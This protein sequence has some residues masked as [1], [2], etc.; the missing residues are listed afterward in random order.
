MRKGIDFRS[1]FAILCVLILF[2]LI[3]F[4]VQVRSE[5]KELL[6]DQAVQEI[7]ENLQAEYGAPGF[8]VTISDRKGVIGSAS[9]GVKRIGGS[10]PLRPDSRFHIG[11][12]SKPI[13]SSAIGSLV[14]EGVLGWDSRV[15]DLF[16]EF[17]KT[18]KP[19]YG[20][21]T[22]LQLLSHTSGIQ[23]FEEDEEFER[24]PEWNG[25]ARERRKRFAKW[26]FTLKPVAAPGSESVYSNAG[27][28]VAAAMAE[29]A[30]D[31]S[32]EHIVQ[33]TVFDPLGMKSAGVG[34]PAAK[35]ADAP[36]GHS[37]VNGQW[38]AHDP[39]QKVPFSDLIRPAGDFHMT[40]FDLAAFGRA[41]MLGLEGID[42]FLHSSTIR[43]I[44]KEVL[45]GYA[46]GWNVR[47]KYDSHLGGLE[48]LHTALLMIMKEDGRVY[49]LA[50]NGE[51]DDTSIFGKAISQIRRL[52]GGP[53]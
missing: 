13:T 28:A 4:E 47:E 24:A 39:G 42:G 37:Q 38:V 2:A 12:I 53:P 48:G 7:L 22:L 10:D 1:E 49:A 45:D 40:L 52:E 34:P 19:E 8:A 9:V 20:S 3:A 18:S 11:S 46:L 16:P 15:M 17:R 32:F 23:P 27:Y 29:Q 5:S 36:W 44:H 25:D 31:E 21:V 43:I 30:A 6:S 35:Y 14:E 50:V 26:V 41:H 33:R 51:T